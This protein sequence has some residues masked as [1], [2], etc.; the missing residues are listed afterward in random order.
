MIQ[1]I[2]NI[3]LRKSDNIENSYEKMQ[4]FYI[5]ESKNFAN[6][7]LEFKGKAIR[8][9]E[10]QD[11][12]NIDVKDH[13]ANRVGLLTASLQLNTLKIDDI[14]IFDPILHRKG[15]GTELLRLAENY[16]KRIGCEKII[17]FVN[18]YPTTLKT[19]RPYDHMS[20]QKYLKLFYEKNG[21]KIDGN[22]GSKNI[23]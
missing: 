20:A 13:N 23:S 3:F 2:K 19:D 6:K 22:Y 1:K 4:E 12:I 7:V 8:M 14:I 9:N 15:I 11:G 5:S 17:V 10:S 16:A 21:Y 18:A